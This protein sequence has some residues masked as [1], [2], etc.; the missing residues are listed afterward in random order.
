MKQS[1]GILIEQNIKTV[2]K[3]LKM[4][5]EIAGKPRSF[6]ELIDFMDSNKAT[7]H[8]FVSTLENLGYIAKNQEDKYQLTPKLHSMGTKG[9]EQF[10][11]IQ[12]AKPY[13]AELANEVN[14]SAVIAGYTNDT[15]YYL[16]KIESP[17]ALRIVVEPGKTAP[18]YS[19]ASGKLYLAH[20]TVE[21]LED[22]LD[23]QELKPITENTITDKEAMK[24]E[25]KMIQMQGYAVDHEEWEEYLRGVA[26]PIYDYSNQLV[27]ALCIAGVSY[28]FTEEKVQ[29]VVSKASE[30]AKEISSLLGY[31]NK[32]RGVLNEKR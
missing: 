21:Q 11:L 19:V 22:Y 3:A 6:S 4:L 13:L 14:E 17:S 7:I 23:R 31:V 25:L 10:D 32:E 20:L 15:V 5:E 30:K 26:F 28:R 16:D 1:G 29:T 27:S 8:R 18:L 2:E 24:K 12:I 9:L